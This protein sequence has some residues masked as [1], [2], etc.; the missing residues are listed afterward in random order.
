MLPERPRLVVLTDITSNTPGVREPDDAQSMCRLMLYANCFR[1]E[2]LFATSNMGHGQ[3]CRPEL[4]REIV[5]AYAESHASLSKHDPRYPAPDALRAGIAAG[6]PV[7]GPTVAPEAC[8][9]EAFDS[10]ASRRL[11][12]IID[13]DEPDPV[14][15]SVWGGTADLAQA[16]WRVST[17]R[18]VDQFA[19][20]CDRVRV[21]ACYDQDS[22]GAWIRQTFRRVWYWLRTHGVRGMY[23]DGDRSLSS[24]E[25]VQTFIKPHGKLGQLYPDYRGGDIFWTTHGPVNGIKEGDTPT[26]LG[27]VPIEMHAPLIRQSDPTQGGWGGRGVATPDNPRHFVD[28]AEPDV[29][30]NPTDVSPLTAAVH[31]WRAAFQADFADRLRLA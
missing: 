9:G 28:A 30:E 13:R 22:T 4:I 14:W 12:D 2:G 5:D 18:D 6:N 29:P 16:L 8:V 3:V 7:A 15:I 20:F 27:L 25:W 24:S 10:D 19:R 31:R 1:I 26:W 23:R 11:I 21:I 17:E